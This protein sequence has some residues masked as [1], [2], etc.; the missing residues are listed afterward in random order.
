MD[1][2]ELAHY[3]AMLPTVETWTGARACHH[4]WATGQG[5]GHVGMRWVGCFCRACWSKDFGNCDR[6]GYFTIPGEATSRNEP[7]ITFLEGKEVA[8]RTKEDEIKRSLAVS[9]PITWL[10]ELTLTMLCCST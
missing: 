4:F 10:M 8:A 3:R 5:E 6:R 9:S 1:M 7:Q 2:F